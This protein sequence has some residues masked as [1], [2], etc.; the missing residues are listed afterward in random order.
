MT[1]FRHPK[2]DVAAFR[3]RVVVAM[4]FVLVCFGLLAARFHY[5]QV[6]RYD[7]FRS[8]ATTIFIRARRA[9]GLRCC[10]SFR[11]GG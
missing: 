8:C 1:D 6:V 9:T 3:R 5:L 7:Y 2:E 10:R 11:T 4:M